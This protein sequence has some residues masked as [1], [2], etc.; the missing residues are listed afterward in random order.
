MKPLALALAVALSLPL[1]ACGPRGAT[2]DA[3]TT[4]DGQAA[5]TATEAAIDG[6]P[7]LQASPLPLG[8]P[9]FDAIAD[10]HYGP[11]IEQGMA[12]QR[13]EVGA[14]AGNTEPA[15]FENTIVAME[16][17]GDLLNRSL[18]IF[19]N[20]AGAHTN[21]VLQATQADLAPKLAAHM[22]A[23]LLDEALFGRVADLYGRRADLGLDAEQLHL[24]ERYH[25]DFVRAGARLDAAQKEQLKA[26]NAELASLQTR[27]TQNVLR[28]TN[29]S[30]V[31]FD[32]REQLAGL[33]D[34]AIEAAA[35]AA[36]AAGHEG[37]FQIALQNTT[38][39][40]P[41]TDMT[42]RAA[43]QRLHE[44]SVDRGSRGGEFDN[45]EIV[46]R[47]VRLRAERAVLLGYPNHAAYVLE[48]ATAGSTDA[49]N[50]MMARLAPAAVANARREA[51]DIQALIDAEQGG[52]QVAAWDWAHYAEKVRQQRYDLDANQ[53]KPYFE[54]N[55]V[56]VDGVFHAATELFGISF[57][58]RTDLPVYHPDVR[59]WDVFDADGS[60][61]AIFIGD[62]YARPSKRGGAW[63]NAYVQQNDLL[64]TLP[65]VGNHQN[66]PKPP[67][68]E[69]TLMTFDEV[70]TMFHE[71]GHALHGMFSKVT[72]PRFSGTSV[73]RD[74]V[75]FPS[76]VN[77]M[78]AT[79][80]SV[81]AN[82]ARHHETGE[83]LPQELLDKVLASETF[84]QGFATTE[85]LA[86]TLLD[87]AFH[88]IGPD[89]VP[90][91][92]IA[93]E[94]Q[95]LADAGVD[96]P[97]VPPR[98][99]TTY[100]SHTF[101]G[102]YSAGYYSYIWSEVLDAASVQWFKDNG[103][104]TRENGRH[105]RETLL[106]RGGSRPAMD[107]Y[108]DFTGAEPDLQPLLVRRGLLD[109]PARN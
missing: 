76:Q 58:E 72:Y 34:A 12:R 84:N 24:L 18:R 9:P 71:F 5:T 47:I 52:F 104:L 94:K 3:G 40:P 83:P 100:F 85:Y 54:L 15:S 53:L 21:D 45:R 68:G 43:R 77:E 22:D 102:G 103:G 108:R 75:E 14:I 41:L 67:Q 87:Q 4:G 19:Q 105:F 50:A 66:I 93:F 99:R 70:T 65:V 106:S 8:Y 82:Y 46:A 25:T 26:L 37:K 1:A 17:S 81:L 11:A 92:V 10:Q 95:A 56:L 48:D 97:P 29:A 33:S 80:P 42:D 59:V 39:Q 63:M 2:G 74:F 31:L 32:S 64:G 28:E 86:A 107:L 91:D 36:A 69:P 109:D 55:R 27:F 49:V 60:Q 13:E 38:G 101:A 57:K 89:R 98:Y 16:R 20:L 6:N 7:L 90:T 79:W 30:A 35:A 44:A 51:A 23:I 61:L 88:Q 96:F 73:P 78:W 62:F